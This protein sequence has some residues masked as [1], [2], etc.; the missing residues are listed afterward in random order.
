MA[1]HRKSACG[2]THLLAFGR[3]R[4]IGL[5]VDKIV[6]RPIDRRR[7]GT[8]DRILLDVLKFR[9]LICLVVSLVVDI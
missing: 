6:S 1:N 9:T 3:R 5:I 2:A 4:R 7:V 8:P